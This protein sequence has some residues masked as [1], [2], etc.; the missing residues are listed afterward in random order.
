MANANR[1]THPVSTPKS[2]ALILTGKITGGGAASDCTNPES[3]LQGGGEISACVYHAATGK[4]TVT[5]RHLYPALL[6]APVSV[7][8]G[9]TDGL[10][11]SFLSI[12][13][14][15]GT[16]EMETWV[17]NTAT[18]MATTDTLHLMWVVRNSG[19]NA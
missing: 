19:R 12:D 16:A 7:N 9:T 8:V 10:R 17:G 6:C 5:F 14:T 15:T 3:A 4:Y 18:D 11:A 2:E 13:I 1:S